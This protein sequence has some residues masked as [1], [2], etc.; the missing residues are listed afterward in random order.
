M[1]FV[2]TSTAVYVYINGEDVSEYLLEGS[3]SDD[4]VYTNSIVTT[5]GQLVLGTSSDILDF[6]RTLY[7]IGSKVSIW[8]KL[9]NGSIALH[10]KGT[11]YII[12]STASPE[13]LTLTLDV[14]CSLAF[15]Y[16][17]E[18]LY[19]VAVNGLF[20][21]LSN[22]SYFMIEQR[23][24]STLST[25]LEAENA[26]IYQDPYGNV[27]KISAFGTDGLGG[28]AAN[29]KFTSFDKHTAISIESIS[30]TA[31]ENNIS[32]VIVESN[33]EIP[34]LKG[35]NEGPGTA[36]EPPPFITSVT[37]RTIDRAFFEVNQNLPNKGTAFIGIEPNAPLQS[38]GNPDCGKPGDP[39]TTPSGIGSNYKAYGGAKIVNIPVQEQVTNGGFT[40]YNGPGRQVDYEDAWEACSASTWANG[41]I[42]NSMNDYLNL[43]NREL[44]EANALLSKANQ[45]YDARNNESVGSAKYIFHNCNATTFYETAEEAVERADFRTVQGNSLGLGAENKY[46]VSNLTQTFNFFNFDGALIKKVVR[47]YQQPTAWDGARIVIITEGP[48]LTTISATGLLVPGTIPNG[49][50]TNPTGINS[51][52]LKLASESVKTYKYSSL[53]TTEEE[54]FEDYL[55]PKQG[56]KRVNYSS[57]S[58]T[59]PDAPGRIIQKIAADGQEYCAEDTDNKE[60]KVKVNVLGASNISGSSWFGVGKAY[61]KTI[62]FPA[63]FKPVLPIYNRTT[64]TCSPINAAGQIAIYES[65]LMKYAI[66]TIKK[67]TGDNR[68]L[69]ITEKLRA[70][71]FEYYPFYPVNISM[72]SIGRA[73]KTRVAASNWVFDSQNAVCSFD[74]FIVADIPEPVFADPSSKSIYIKTDAALTLTTN[75]LKISQTAHSIIVATL[76]TTG[77]LLLSGTPVTVG[78][79]ILVSSVTSNLLTFTPTGAGTEFINFT[80]KAITSTGATLSS[81]VDIY[82]SIT[83]VLLTIGNYKAD[84]GDFTL[85][86]TN[87]GLNIDASDLSSTT[88][89]GGPTFMN[90][91]DFDA[92]G[93]MALPALIFP[94][95]VP[96]TNG[97]VDPEVS[98]GITVKNSTNNTINSSTLATA[99]GEFASLFDVIIDFDVKVEIILLLSYFLLVKSGWDYGSFNV[100]LGTS[101]NLG[102]I[103]DPN[104]YNLNFGTFTTPA[105]PVLQSSVV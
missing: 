10:P 87:G 105:E 67:I 39:T 60:L 77:T 8:V 1:S 76:P 21:L 96:A 88:S 57:S 31:I 75:S 44:A 43:I 86:L 16:D 54:I 70:E 51:Y 85:N 6:N 17:K 80:Y 98:Y 35:A 92:G 72:E 2:N 37:T 58:S 23:D 89:G 19:P 5:T 4:S 68:G 42:T 50:V 40:S 63:T 25:L 29:A 26:I 81:L 66:N 61:E 62:N 48:S 78:Q 11:L 13:S 41:A 83:T 52:N 45:H 69:R 71:I 74:C 82:P 3:L 100:G 95:G 103:L 14:G 32:A 20:D 28:Q 65:I 27:Q 64:N 73:F 30:E 7:P 38:E 46:A 47:N 9:E 93:A 59:S 97:S 24:L 101:I 55:N 79:S 84:G 91:G 49:K 56:F 15:M 94:V 33:V 102:T 53:Y 36:P 34:R 12:N 99:S 90:A 104:G 18:D 22:I